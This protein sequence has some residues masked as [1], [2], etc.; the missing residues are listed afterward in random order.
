MS[1]VPSAV[2]AQSADVRPRGLPIGSKRQAGDAL[3]G[4]GDG[5]PP[6]VRHQARESMAVMVVSA[7]MSSGV[8]LGLTLL[9]GL[10]R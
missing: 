10:S 9:V 8:A 4:A 3:K 6:R 5:T 2:W 7:G 1:T